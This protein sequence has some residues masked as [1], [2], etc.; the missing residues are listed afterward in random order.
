MLYFVGGRRE[1]V[2]LEKICLFVTG[3]DNEPVLGFERKPTIEFSEAING[4]I[5]TALTCIN[6]LT[7]PAP[8]LEYPLTKEVGR[9]FV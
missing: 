3:N 2:N 9:E 8:T 1:K 4:F 7:L 6:R 5:P